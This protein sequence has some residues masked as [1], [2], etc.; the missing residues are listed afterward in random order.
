[1]KRVSFPLMTLLVMFVS[2]PRAFALGTEEFGNKPLSERNYTDWPGIMPLVNDEA[3]VYSNWVNGN[4]HLY[5]EGGTAALNSAL[6]DFAA[7]KTET[8]RVIFR[9]GPGV[10]SSFHGKRVPCTWELHLVGGI[11]GHIATLDKGDLIWSKF[12]VLTVYVGDEIDMKKLIIPDGVTP[13]N[14]AEIKQQYATAVLKSTDKTVRGWGC[15]NL[16]ALDPYDG[17][18][19]KVI[20][21]RLQDDDNWVRQNA[22][23]ALAVFGAKA[24]TTL[25]ALREAAT[26]DDQNLKEAA[27]KAIAAVEAAPDEIEAERRHRAAIAEI[28]K[29]LEAF[30][31]R[32]KS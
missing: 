20:A 16:A 32:A 3:R 8:R 15:G 27:E 11:A 13:L 7:V 22:A 31:K 10:A 18:S 24:K 26:S 28:D 5:Y 14:L 23:G 19:L 1:M 30:R 9:P 25:D 6:K 17:E 29:A 4:E 21:D 2:A 12:P